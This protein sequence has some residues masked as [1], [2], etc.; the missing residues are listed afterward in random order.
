MV[1]TS[2]TLLICGL[3]LCGLEE[4]V[5]SRRGYCAENQCF[6]LFEQ[7]GDYP[8]AHRGCG[9]TGGQLFTF[10]PVHEAKVLSWPAGS[11]WVGESGAGE[12][13]AAGNCSYISLS[14][15]RKITASWEACNKDLEGFL[16]QY[17]S[18][19]PCV[20][21]QAPGA[22]VKYTTQWGFEVNDSETFPLGTIA[23]AGKAGGKYP[24]S[25]HVCVFKDWVRAPWNCEVLQG[26]CEHSCS[27]T[28]NTC[29]CPA[30]QILH[31]NSITCTKDP[32]A[33]CQQECQREGDG[34]VCKCRKGYKLARDG[35]S[36]TGEDKECIQEECKDGF[37]KEDGV[38]VDVSICAKCEHMRC[39]KF[40]GVYECLCRKGFRVST[41]DPT[42]CELDCTERDCPAYCIPNLDNDKKDMNQCFCPDGYIIDIHP[43]STVQICTDINECETT[44]CE[45]KCE[46]VFGDY[47]CLCNEGFVLH[48]KDR[49][50]PS[51]EEGDGSGWIPPQPPTP[52]GAHP[53]AVPPYVKTGS[54]LGITVFMALCGVLLFL[55]VRNLVKRCGKFEL[56]SF[57]HP[58]IDI[59]YLQQVTTETYK[60]LS[61]DKPFKSDSQIQ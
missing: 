8:G 16:C 17:P 41:K 52:A 56:S 58:D 50:V 43:N 47:R 29:T 48:G 34:Y 40:S 30:G 2:R 4:V 9:D 22:Q 38:C 20:G 60:R 42:K 55:L 32:C 27:K 53:A 59:F 44:S 5:S 45:H 51:E 3:F 35:R 54:I 6:A 26:G 15:G 18:D 37:C 13:A 31:S 61:F 46:N 14:M 11:Y 57:K 10:S 39:E 33:H 7:L 24:D 36:C 12:E 1:P 23:V 28:S 21:L 19:E 25:K 49:C